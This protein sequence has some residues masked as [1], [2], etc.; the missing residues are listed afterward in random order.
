M[1]GVSSFQIQQ[2]KNGHPKAVPHVGIPFN[3]TGGTR[4][5]N[6]VIKPFSFEERIKKTM[7]LK[8]ERISHAH[9]A[10]KKVQ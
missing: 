8:A 4:K 6:T 5:R 7:E 10:V 9:E 2:E 1:K 3:A